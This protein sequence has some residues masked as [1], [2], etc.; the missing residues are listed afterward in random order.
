MSTF[1]RSATTR[2]RPQF[3]PVGKARSSS[4]TVKT[5]GKV[6][7][8]KRH[9]SSYVKSIASSRPSFSTL[10]P[11]QGTGRYSI[12]SYD[13]ARQWL[14]SICANAV[15]SDHYINADNELVCVVHQ[16][17]GSPY[18]VY[19]KG[20]ELRIERDDKVARLY[21]RDADE[22]FHGFAGYVMS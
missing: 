6:E 2:Q 22:L 19:N 20:N 17:Y 8:P 9:S 7:Q 13:V 1:Y 5:T 11:S 14:W 18:V 3:V 10:S 4:A 16:G 12:K 15:R 21:H